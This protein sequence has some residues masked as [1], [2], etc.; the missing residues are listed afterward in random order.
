ME[1][2][3]LLKSRFF[4]QRGLARAASAL[5]YVGVREGCGRE[6]IVKPAIESVRRIRRRKISV[7]MVPH[8]FSGLREALSVQIMPRAGF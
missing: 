5:E 3:F 8:M 4:K 2:Q 1:S 6:N 7:H